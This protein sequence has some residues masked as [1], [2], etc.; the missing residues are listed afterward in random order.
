MGFFQLTRP[1]NENIILTTCSS[2]RIP[3]AT[4]NRI[5]Q[6][7]A[8]NS[9]EMVDDEEVRGLFE[10]TYRLAIRMVTANMLVSMSGGMFG[11]GKL[12][13]SSGKMR[14]L[15]ED[16]FNRI[17]ALVNELLRW[18]PGRTMVRGDV[19]LVVGEV[20][21]FVT[22]S[23]EAEEYA[24]QH[25]WRWDRWR[26][27]QVS[28]ITDNLVANYGHLI[29]YHYPVMK[30]LDSDAP[31]GPHADDFEGEQEA[32]EESFPNAQRMGAI[33]R[34]DHLVIYPKK[35]EELFYLVEAFA[36]WTDG[37]GDVRYMG[38]QV[39]TDIWQGRM[40]GATLRG[41][42]N[43]TTW[44]RHAGSHLQVTCRR[45]SLGELVKQGHWLEDNV[46]TEEAHGLEQG[47][48]WFNSINPDK[49]WASKKEDKP[50]A[51]S[52]DPTPKVSMGDGELGG[53][54]GARNPMNG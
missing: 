10:T 32:R 52:S 48:H 53:L 12:Q 34:A 25:A 24:N 9:I 3:N 35:A 44:S 29:D 30:A 2:P 39:P 6:I 47:W 13:F 26:V 1:A 41:H 23:T 36:Q 21:D 49:Y 20:S 15:N 16:V 45:E 14:T 54:G 19:N 8:E 11:A 43:L 46:L 33:T 37:A 27:P 22:L 40:Y 18:Y 5:I 31:T 28:P 38:T 51:F 42:R 50:S 17:P 7:V 4:M